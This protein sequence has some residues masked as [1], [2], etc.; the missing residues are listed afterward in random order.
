MSAADASLFF[1]SSAMVKRFAPERGSRIVV[2]L[3]RPSAGN[4]CKPN[5]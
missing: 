3:L 2:S 5:V 1:D 4:R